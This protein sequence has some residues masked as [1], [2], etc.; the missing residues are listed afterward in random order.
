MRVF[1]LATDLGPT[2]T[3][4]RLSLLVPVL[5][6]RGIEQ[7]VGVIGDALAGPV[8]RQKLPLR[9]FLDIA[10][11][12]RIRKAI[13]EFRP[14]VVHCWGR[15]A[16]VAVNIAGVSC[17]ILS[18][19]DEPDSFLANRLALRLNLPPMVKLESLPD[20][21]MSRTALGYS[22]HDL[23]I[24]A[25]DRFEKPDAARLAIWTMDLLK[26]S[27]PSWK[28]LLIG[29]GPA[30]GAAE[31]FLAKLSVDDNRTRFL[32]IVPDLAP[33]LAA[34]DCLWQTRSRGGVHFTLD[35][36]AAGVPVIANDNPDL[37]SILDDANCLRAADAVAIAKATAALFADAAQRERLQD[38]G[39]RTAARFP[40][41][42]VVAQLLAAYSR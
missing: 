3:G 19:F 16:A 29:G 25:V 8:D 41:E 34:A 26:V 20:R 22:E 23:V 37:A 5:A 38:A 6:K 14:D 21:S 4:R 42:P 24:V 17:K 10:G 15:R 18:T 32:G 27:S 2:A 31:R 1:H 13:A 28:L 36:M 39:R 9:P 7:S 35:A 33:I 12:R 30:R 11:W 40:V